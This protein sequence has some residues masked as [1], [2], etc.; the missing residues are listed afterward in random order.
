MSYTKKSLIEGENIISSTTFSF[1]MMMIS[2]VWYAT[3]SI[4]VSVFATKIGGDAIL[5]VYLFLFLCLF[6]F[7]EFI[8]YIS[9]EFSV[10]NKKILSKKGLISRQTDELPIHKVEGIDVQQGILGRILNIGNVVVTGTGTQTV[11]FE[12][13]DDPVEIKKAIQ[14]AL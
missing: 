12:G 1:K 13:I 10:T 14:A 3:I 8:S 11:V 6:L 2:L 5:G 9:T 4:G 7:N